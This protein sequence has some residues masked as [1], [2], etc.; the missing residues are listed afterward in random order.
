MT[1]LWHDT[2]RTQRLEKFRA[3][4]MN[5]KIA[6]QVK[7]G[8]RAQEL[9]DM[10]QI[11]TSTVIRYARLHGIKTPDN[12]TASREKVKEAVPLTDAK[13]LAMHAKW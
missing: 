12:F 5:G 13:R 11:S 2:L 1:T 6:R 10:Y 3:A 4:C 9:A 8:M 7:D